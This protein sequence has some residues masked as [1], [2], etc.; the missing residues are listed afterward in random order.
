MAHSLKNDV[1]NAVMQ[2]CIEKDRGLGERQGAEA[3]IR[4]V[5]SK[6]GQVFQHPRIEARRDGAPEYIYAEIG[7]P[8]TET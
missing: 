3:V 8:A 7:R 6:V 1:G 2:A 4:S 5:V